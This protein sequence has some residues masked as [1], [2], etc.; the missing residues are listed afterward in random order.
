MVI[1]IV[2]LAPIGAFT[3]IV[4]NSRVPP[5]PTAWESSL[6]GYSSES[7]P[8]V[9]SYSV[10]SLRVLNFSNVNP[11]E[12]EY[13]A[14]STSL[15]NGSRLWSTQ[16]ITNG[17]ACLSAGL[18][19][20]DHGVFFIGVDSVGSNQMVLT[21]MNA[22]T[23]VI[24]SSNP[25]PQPGTSFWP[26]QLTFAGYDGTVYAVGEIGWT[27]ISV[28]ALSLQGGGA[29]LW[30]RNVTVPGNSGWDNSEPIVH[31][32]AK[33]VAFF[34]HDQLRIFGSSFQTS[35]SAAYSGYLPGDGLRAGLTDNVTFLTGTPVID[36]MVYYLTGSYASPRVCGAN[37]TDGS[38][39]ANFSVPFSVSVNGTAEEL[40]ATG[41][42]LMV[43][44]DTGAVAF[45]LL[46]NMLWSQHVRNGG[47]FANPVT[48]SD[49]LV[50][51]QWQNSEVYS[52]ASS[53]S[54]LVYDATYVIVNASN[55]R[56]LWNT[57]YSA[58]IGIPPWTPPSPDFPPSYLASTYSNGLLLV[59][60]RQSLCG[61]E[62]SHLI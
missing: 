32:D 22:S 20:F 25:E 27:T 5:F 31:A 41:N 49:D 2:V 58:W 7:S 28:E 18:F 37:L 34:L 52:M 53:T 19:Y 46:G 8:V 48:L 42:E 29:V 47:Q 54:G 40:Y 35:G 26:E 33:G 15:L 57:V 50:L 43:T 36:G 1:L 11:D 6:P 10:Y 17:L 23:G 55:G 51:L 24:L 56:V 45:D 38:L 14:V 13:Q 9:Q 3:L 61:V 44:G 39:A 62:V 60:G 21:E 12:C 4:A 30:D 16:I 59:E